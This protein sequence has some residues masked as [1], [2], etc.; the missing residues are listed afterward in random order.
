MLKLLL[1]EESGERSLVEASVVI[2][3]L[4]SCGRHLIMTKR[5]AVVCWGNVV[6]PSASFANANAVI[7]ALSLGNTTWSVTSL[8]DVVSVPGTCTWTVE[9][10]HLVGVSEC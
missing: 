1:V 4:S 2:Q 6:N 5:I 9:F 10:E 7:E 3:T 8:V